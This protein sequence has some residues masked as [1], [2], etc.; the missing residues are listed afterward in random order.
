MRYL[1]VPSGPAVLDG[2]AFLIMLV[3]SE[4]VG[5]SKLRLGGNVGG[6]QTG[7][8]ESM[9]ALVSM[10][11]EESFPLCEN[12]SAVGCKFR[13]TSYSTCS[14]RSCSRSGHCG[15]CLMRYVSRVA[16]GAK[17]KSLIHSCGMGDCRRVCSMV[18]KS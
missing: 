1:V 6:G 18:S 10:H 9:G 4:K 14:C 13:K 17:L 12:S 8:L 2:C 3:N 15:G 7:V 5:G 16:H 11:D